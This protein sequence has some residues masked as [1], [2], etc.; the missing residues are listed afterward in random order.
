MREQRYRQTLTAALTVAL[1]SD[2]VAIGMAA[3]MS[4]GRPRARSQVWADTGADRTEYLLSGFRLK[5]SGP[6]PQSGHLGCDRRHPAP[7]AFRR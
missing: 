1:S 5:S 4:Q 7:P 2:T 6:A 3:G